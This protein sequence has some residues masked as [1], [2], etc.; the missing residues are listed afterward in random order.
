MV[1]REGQKH[2]RILSVSGLA[3]GASDVHGHDLTVI[4]RRGYVFLYPFQLLVCGDRAGRDLV[5]AEKR[6]F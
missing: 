5:L 4:S 2:E 6:V 3:T 1:C